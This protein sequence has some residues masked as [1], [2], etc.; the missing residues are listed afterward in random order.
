MNRFQSI[1]VPM[2]VV[3]AL[4]VACTTPTA[5]PTAAPSPVPT[6]AVLNSPL[7]APAAD[8]VL[9]VYERS[10]GIAG[11]RTSFTV[12]GDGRVI[13]SNGTTTRANPEA[14]KALVGVLARPATQSLA[15]PAARP[16]PDCFRYT[17]TLPSQPKPITLVTY[18][19]TTNPPELNALLEAI[20]AVT[21]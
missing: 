15:S 4:G 20:Q 8:T 11:Q 21:R 13:T 3:A 14:L 18:D 10:G 7:S 17:I 12:Y 16:C 5:P 2:L 6:T 19:G 9:V 1:L